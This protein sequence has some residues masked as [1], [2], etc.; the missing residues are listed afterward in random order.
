LCFAQRRKGA[1]ARCIS[2]RLC[3]FA[4][5]TRLAEKPIS[6]YC[7]EISTYSIV[8]DT[9][10]WHKSFT[11][12][13]KRTVMPRAIWSGAIA[14]GL[15]NIPIKIYS[16]VQGSELDL[17]MLDKKDHSNIRFKR[18]NENTGKE[19]AWENIVRGFKYDEKYVVL[20]EDDFAK[21]R[22]EKNK[23][24]EIG[25]FVDEKE[26][27]ASYYEMPYYLAP[28]K[29][30]MKAY[31]LL[32]DALVKTGKVGLGTY[33]LRNRESL[34][35]IKP[36]GNLLLLNKIRFAQE[37]RS[38][39]DIDIDVKPSK[40]QELKMAIALIEQLTEKFDIKAYKD[41]YSDEL[42][43]LIEKKAKGK[44]VTT[45]KLRVVHSRSRDLMGQLK[46]SLDKDKKTTRK[47]AS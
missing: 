37:I 36:M 13:E 45:P 12:K 3:A 38:P 15:V 4:R 39:K 31:N 47:K 28:E 29:Q 18:V 23:L 1:K 16:A 34:G 5:N 17:D 32:R 14:F 42:M 6:A 20:T 26:I 27:D 35:V 10:C 43:K 44:K 40:P 41:T 25:D 8:N 24:I 19:V 30:G 22:P 2:L 7:P 11:S 33:V 46:A 21:V 9:S